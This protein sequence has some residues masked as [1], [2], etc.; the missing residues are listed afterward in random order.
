M[1]KVKFDQ[2]TFKKEILTL[3]SEV[4][5]KNKMIDWLNAELCKKCNAVLE[6]EKFKLE[7]GK[8]MKK[9]KNSKKKAL[10]A[11]ERQSTLE[12][13]LAASQLNMQRY[14]TIT[15]RQ[16]E[17]IDNVRAILEKVSE[18]RNTL[19][20]TG[21]KLKR[22]V[23]ASRKKMAK[24][25]GIKNTKALADGVEFLRMAQACFST[26]GLI[27]DVKQQNTEI[28]N[29]EATE[30]GF[31]CAISH[32]IFVDPVRCS[33]GQVYERKFIQKW[34][35]ANNTSPIT[36]ARLNDRTLVPD[37]RL[38]STIEVWK[39]KNGYD[40]VVARENTVA[41]EKNTVDLT[42]EAT[43]VPMIEFQ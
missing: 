20:V 18:E 6:A 33:D 17:E 7:K 11:D 39:K 40:E 15:I 35:N 16:G 8:L 32:E 27:D 1:V 13:E 36:N 28:L 2:E 5:K 12:R 23:E 14:R 29:D 22:D 19:K 41:I 31:I 42:S 9:L 37:F 24:L 43:T 38:R 25:E 4:H 3:K 26:T 10:E 30:Y 21:E 34:F